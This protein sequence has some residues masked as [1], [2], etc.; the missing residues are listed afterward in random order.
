MHM[1]MFVW[2]VAH[3]HYVLFGGSV[4]ALFAGLHYWWPKAF[5]RRLDEPLGLIHFWLMLV[6]MNP[7]FS[8]C[9]TWG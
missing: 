2:I 5:G 6:A 3:P 8:P 1:P 4:F 7:T 9:T